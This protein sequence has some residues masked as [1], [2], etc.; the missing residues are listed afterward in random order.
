MNERP[1]QKLKISHVRL[2]NG[3]ACPESTTNQINQENQSVA[4]YQ[5]LDRRIRARQKFEKQSCSCD[6]LLYQSMGTYFYNIQLGNGQILL[7][8]CRPGNVTK[9]D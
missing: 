2:P 6:Q 3:I 4:G 1:R 9:R 8:L 5:E 7:P